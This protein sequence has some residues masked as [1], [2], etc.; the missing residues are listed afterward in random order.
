M[1]DSI[2][3]ISLNLYTSAKL[4]DIQFDESRR[5]KKKESQIPGISCKRNKLFGSRAC[6]NDGGMSPGKVRLRT[7]H[8]RGDLR[9]TLRYNFIHRVRNAVFRIIFLGPL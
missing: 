6:N 8:P 4:I 5:Y 9:F 1:F 3:M 2:C 7:P